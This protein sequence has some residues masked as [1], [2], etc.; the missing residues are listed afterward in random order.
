MRYFSYLILLLIVLTTNTYAQDNSWIEDKTSQTGLDSARGGYVYVMDI[1]NDFYPDIAIVE[2]SLIKGKIHLFL[3]KQDPTSSNP[4]DRIFEDITEW[5]NIDIRRN[6]EHGRVIDNIVF[7]DIDND[8]D[9]DAITGI[10]YHRWE[11]YHP[12]SNDPGDRCE[13]LLNRGNGRFDLVENSGLNTLGPHTGKDLGLVNATGFSMLDFDLDGKLD[14]FVASWF[15][16]YKNNIMTPSYFLKGN[17]DGTFTDISL[18]TRIKSN[19]YPLYGVNATD[20][21]NDGWMD[22]ATAPYCRSGGSLWKNLQDGSFIDVAT[23]ANYNT[24]ELNGEG[25]GDAA[26]TYAKPLCTWAVQPADYDNDGDI[27][28]YFTLVHGGFGNDVF[29]NPCGRSSV[30]LN[31]GENLDYELEW[32]LDRV[33]RRPPRSSHLGDYD[34]TWIDLDNDML[35]D[36]VMGNGGYSVSTRLYIIQQHSDNYLYDISFNLGIAGVSTMIDEVSSIQPIDFDLDGDDDILLSHGDGDPSPLQEILLIENKIGDKNNWT[37]IYLYPPATCNQS[38]IGCR[39]TVYAVGI[40]QMREVKAGFG[41]FGGQQPFLTNFGLGSNT[42]VDSVTIRWQTNPI[43]YTTIYN[44]PIND[45]IIINKQGL[46]GTLSTNDKL[47]KEHISIYPNP[48]D[49][50]IWIELPLSFAKTGGYEIYDI[51]GKSIMK[52]EYKSDYSGLFELQLS[53]C[54]NGYY[55]LRVYNDL[56]SEYVSFS[57]L[58]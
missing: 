3:N 29:G 15:E 36:L 38:A 40:T 19:Y 18:T 53:S 41:H 51:N 30:I 58:R 4:K 34:A 52:G 50:K 31:H 8:G 17:G 26:M 22:I 11:Y 33:E 23:T 27:D 6:G 10:Y 48:A 25:W 21:N 2:A 46:W 28:F 5:S 1:N 13:V 49:E 16:D 35:L 55:V 24:Q 12:D 43:S 7:A 9:A 47:S 56:R 45:K 57:V 39:I 32:A 44:P 37:S 42:S 14:L 20:W 54:S